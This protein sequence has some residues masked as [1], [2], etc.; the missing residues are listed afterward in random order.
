MGAWHLNKLVNIIQMRDSGRSQN[1][2]NSASF[3]SASEK[4]VEFVNKRCA[5][6]AWEPNIMD[7][8]ANDKG[9]MTALGV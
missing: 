5:S 3:V 1:Q 4:L 9:V 2:G 6:F 8:A 7:R